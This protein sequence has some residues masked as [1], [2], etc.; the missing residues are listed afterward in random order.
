MPS[1]VRPIALLVACG[2]I[3]LAPCS[4]ASAAKS[5]VTFTSESAEQILNT[6]RIATMHAGSMIGTVT[7]VAPGASFVQKQDSGKT[8]GQQLIVTSLGGVFQVRVIGSTTYFRDNVVALVGQFGGTANKKYANR[9]ISL[10]PGELDYSA[11]TSAVT[12]PS[13]LMELIPSGTLAK[14]PVANFAGHKCIGV[15][16]HVRQGG[17]RGHQTLWVEVAA[18]HLIAG[19]Q[20]TLDNGSRHQDTSFV[21]TSWGTKVKVVKPKGA[22]PI[23]DTTL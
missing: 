23:T 5:R 3:T 16:T 4:S 14:T 12:L 19:M 22:I 21:A 17:A 1:A 11:V 15:W 2:A 7:V 8:E 9:W 13:L 6:G 10:K 18:P 20:E